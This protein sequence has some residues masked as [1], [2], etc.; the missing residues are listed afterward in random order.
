MLFSEV[1]GQE[2]IKKRLLRSVLENR[3]SH[4][5]LFT[6][7]DGCGKLALAL[8]YATYIQCTGHKE[9]DA[10]GQCPACMKNRKLIHPDL[11]FVFPVISQK[12]QSAVSSDYIKEW[13][14]AILESPYISLNQWLERIGT[15]N[16][17]GIINVKESEEMIR[18]LNFKTYESDYKIMIIWLPEKMNIPTANKLLKILEEPPSATLFLFVSANPDQ[19]LKTVVSRMQIVKIP[20]IDDNSISVALK[21]KFK[22]SDDEIRYLLRQSNGNYNKVLSLIS[23]DNDKQGNLE[24]FIQ[25]M[26]LSY[27]NRMSDTLKWIDDISGIGRERQKSLLAFSIKMVRDNFLL[28]CNMPELT[29]LS[30]EEDEFSVKFSKMINSSNVIPVY[31]ELNKAYFH[32]ER[33]GY[34]KFVFLDLSLKLGRLLR[35]N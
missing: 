8:A 31:E 15:E 19:M 30:K 28:K 27:G 22:L 2:N 7:P 33:N 24:N 17:Q 10:C 13:R 5:Q 12:S 16:K 29:F 21:S 23:H 14:E 34:N 6:G 32:I 1:T 35:I 26:R 11:H 9:D 25:L 18:K 3:I 4:A 20:R